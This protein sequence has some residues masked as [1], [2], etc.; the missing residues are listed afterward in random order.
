VADWLKL[1]PAD[2]AR[3]ILLDI[4]PVGIETVPLRASAGRVL[5]APVL[6]A[7]DVPAE[8][9]SAMDGYAVRADD[10]A[11]ADRSEAGVILRV[12]GAVPAGSTFSGRVGAGE[13]V[14]IATGAVVP[15]GA[16]TVVMVESTAPV[17]PVVGGGGGNAGGGA[18]GGNA[19]VDLGGQ[20][21]VTGAMVR[22]AHIVEAGD[23]LRAGVEVL[24]AGRRLRTGDLAA[25]ATFGMVDVPVFR[26]PRIAVLATG[27]EICAPSETPR[28]GQV[29]DSNQYV[30]AAEVERAGAIAVLG[31]IVADDLDLLRATV[32]RLC[33]EHDGVILSGGSS[34]GP[35]DLTSRAFGA[36]APPG[37]LFHGIDIRPGKP[38][39]F[40]RAGHKPVV[41][42][43]GYPTSSMVVFEAFVRPMLARY[44]GES[45]V[46][47]WP[48]A[49]R[50]RLAR[51]HVKPASREDYLRVRLVARDG[52]LWAEALP[53]G[54]AAI[55][56][57]IFADGL[58]RVPAGAARAQPGS[59]VDVRRFG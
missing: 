30:L 44:G 11:A 7:Q 1:I 49:V 6:A 35:K 31:G 40:A 27:S 42:M 17:M 14:S 54:S 59:P 43:P 5:A 21:R 26:R 16:D 15:D 52:E 39:V 8:R 23:D 41:G 51:E 55:S 24:S 32:L 4:A 19:Y 38:T 18:A 2:D 9:R 37:V 50:A 29:R 46:D 10:V 12:V 20:V 45:V 25:L 58:A 48:V 22:G 3:R 47:A 33:A 56:N 36:L 57:V 13:A 34:V 28:P 53:G